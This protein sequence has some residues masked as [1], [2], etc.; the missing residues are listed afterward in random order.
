MLTLSILSRC[1]K[2]VLL[3]EPRAIGTF[4]SILQDLLH[5]RLSQLLMTMVKLVT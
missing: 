1:K 3:L 5:F 2:L 4:D